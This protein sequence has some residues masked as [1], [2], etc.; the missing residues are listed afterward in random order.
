[1]PK[2]QSRSTFQ[3]EFARGVYTEESTRMAAKFIR[4]LTWWVRFYHPATK[5]LVRESLNTHDEARAE[6]LRQRIELEV[7]LQEPRFQ[8]APLPDPLQKILGG[9]V[10]LGE[11]DLFSRPIETAPAASANPQFP[12]QATMQRRVPIKEAVKD[13]IAFIRAEN[14]AHH[15][16]TKV[17]MLRRFLGSKV[18]AELIGKNQP[19]KGKGATLHPAYFKG[20]FVDELSSTLI[21]RFIESL[22]ISVKTKRHY[23][24]MFHHLFEY[25]LK[26]GL[27]QPT[28]WHY[29][30]PIAALPSYLVRNQRIVFLTEA[31]VEEQLKVL[32]PFPEMRVAAAIMIY[33]G[34]RRA[35]MI[36]LTRDSIAKDL[37]FLSVINQAD[38]E[39]VESSLKTGERA[40]TILP[41]LRAILE[42]HLKDLKSKWVVPFQGKRRWDGNAL[43]RK[44]RLTNKDAGL[45]WNCLHFRH[46][47]ATQR[48][49]DGWSLF[50]IAKEM[51]NSV[52]VVEQYYAGF[53]R[54]ESFSQK[55]H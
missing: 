35:E 2:T 46:T 45:D 47:Y 7:Q 54:P 21:Q 23:R 3:G 26:F 24:E 27:Y 36:W 50:R 19:E 18:M 53:I 55:D 38:E 44:L 5:A 30:N 40:V 49:R 6:L 33:A 41:P 10:H 9:R 52:A 20:E 13:Y 28:N 48:A 34:L 14:A 1:M 39:G 51:G 16:S 15:A 8:M 11:G 32:E 43:G 42:P 12:P 25:C 37:S 4:K 17:S 22:D 31:Q 29:P